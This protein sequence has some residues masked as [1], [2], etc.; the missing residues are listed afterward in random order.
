M[1]KAGV[2]VASRGDVFR[3]AAIEAAVRIEV[4]AK[5][6]D[7]VE[8]MARAGGEEGQALNVGQELEHCGGEVAGGYRVVKVVLEA[9]EVEVHDGDLAVELC[10]EGDGGVGGGV[11]H[12]LR[13]GG[14]DVWELLVCAL[15][16]RMHSR[17]IPG[18]RP[19]LSIQL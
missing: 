11:V 17:N 2:E 19:R 10:V 8:G 9:V 1:V 6:E 3:I 15:E 13:D 4:A 14:R 12:D 7:E 16:M 18:L 5:L